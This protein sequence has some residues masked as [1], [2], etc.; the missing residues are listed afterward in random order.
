MGLYET[1]QYQVVEKVK[2]HNI[3]LRKYPTF[4]MAKAKTK[5]DPGMSGGFN[6]VF[7]YI[8]G[9]NKNNQKISM[10]TPVI[11]EMN[12]NELMTSFVLPSKYS[13]NEIPDPNHGNI[14][15]EKVQEGYFL[16]ISFKGRWTMQNF[17]KHNQVLI[18]Y[19]NNQGHEII[20]DKYILRYQPPMMPGFLRR[21][22]IMY[23]IKK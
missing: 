21:N 5:L 9:G 1:I 19:I 14:T 16:S 20:S 4:Y 3:E 2:E 18:E 6:Q 13:E 8:S 12:E 7:N 15:I 22:E 17:E 10:T 23:R 11:S